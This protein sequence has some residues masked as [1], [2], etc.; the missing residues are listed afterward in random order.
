MSLYRRI[1]RSG[2]VDPLILGGRPIQLSLT[3][4]KLDLDTNIHTNTP[5]VN[6]QFEVLFSFDC[7]LSEL[8]LKMTS[9]SPETTSSY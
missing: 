3:K 8:C 4:L 1:D 6:N 7:L 2:E 9:H 5:S